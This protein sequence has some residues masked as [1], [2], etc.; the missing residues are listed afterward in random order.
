MPL[1]I[2]WNTKFTMRMAHIVHAKKKAVKDTFVSQRKRSEHPLSLPHPLHAH[3]LT[4]KKISEIEKWKIEIDKTH[5]RDKNMHYVCKMIA[6]KQTQ[7][8]TKTTTTIKTAL[9]K[10]ANGKMN[11]RESSSQFA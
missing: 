9:A 8:K 6:L 1:P 7:E 4:R 3:C 10:P 2:A 11:L 5:F